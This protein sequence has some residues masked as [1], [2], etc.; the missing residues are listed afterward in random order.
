MNKII[1][2][3]SL[4]IL[5]I[6]CEDEIN[7]PKPIGYYRIAMPEKTYK[8]YDAD[9]PFRFQMPTYS[10]IAIDPNHENEYCWINVN[11]KQFN[12]KLHLSYKKV[13][14][15]LQDYLEQSRSLAIQHQIKASAMKENLL[16]NDTSKVYGLMYEFGGNTASS[17]QF[18]LTDSTHHFVRAALYF[19]SKPN[20]DSIAPVYDFIKNDIYH[21]IETFHW[22][23]IP[24]KS[25]K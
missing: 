16:I 9:C 19:F 11:W 22:K 5:F 14:N 15:N 21:L 18:Y 6:S 17:L 10:E 2:F 12:A 8:Q 3:F 25:V 24:D 7:V 23:G 20:A 1:V 4:L 13:D